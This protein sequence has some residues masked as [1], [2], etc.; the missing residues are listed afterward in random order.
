MKALVT[1]LLLIGG[2]API[3]RANTTIIRE[4]E[5]RLANAMGA[6]DRWVLLILSD[7]NL[8]V[9]LQCG[10][11]VKSYS[12]QFRRDDWVDTI[13]RM[14]PKSYSASVTEV[15]LLSPRSRNGPTGQYPSLAIARV[16]ETITVSSPQG[17]PVTRRLS[18]LDTWAKSADTWKL[19][20]RTYNAQA[21]GDQPH[22]SF[23][24]Y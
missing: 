24:S 23:P 6:G 18:A 21:C 7:E 1:G 4:Q 9:N 20:H 22:L 2:L 3:D 10:S 11:V 12:I 16:I 13:T 8:G 17:A 5:A 14:Q 15:E 19:V